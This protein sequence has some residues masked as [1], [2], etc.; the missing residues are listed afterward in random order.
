MVKRSGAATKQLGNKTN[1]PQ[2][3]RIQTQSRLKTPGLVQ[4]A[5]VVNEHPSSAPFILQSP[6]KTRDTL[7]LNKP[8]SRRY[9]YC[10]RRYVAVKMAFFLRRQ[11]LSRHAAGLFLL[12]LGVCVCMSQVSSL[13]S[14]EV[15]SDSALDVDTQDTSTRRLPATQKVLQRCVLTQEIDDD[16]DAL[17]Q[18][19]FDGYQ[20]GSTSLL[21]RQTWDVECYI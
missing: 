9:R 2:K 15:G 19:F 20:V 8:H 4:S 12:I 1:S 18:C 21:A 14:V 3:K 6:R 13:E 17:A 5:D 16:E 11:L 10:V 7:D